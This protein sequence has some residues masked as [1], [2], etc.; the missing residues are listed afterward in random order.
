MIL[1]QYLTF[2]EA[3]VIA[4]GT[5]SHPPVLHD[6][7]GDSSAVHECSGVARIAQDLLHSAQRGQLPKYF[8]FARPR[9]GS[10]QQDALLSQPE[11]RLPHTPQLPKLSENHL[12]G[13]LHL[14]IRR[15]LDLA[16]LGSDEADRHFPKGT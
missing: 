10:R 3:L 6:G 9:F 11:Q 5:S 2:S 4:A 15:L 8:L 14:A 12:D 13:L 7:F 1:N 16:L